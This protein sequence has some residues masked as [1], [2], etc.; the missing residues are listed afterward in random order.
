MTERRRF[1]I[2]VR[3]LAEKTCR[4][5]DLESRQG[6]GPAGAAA[7]H[8]AAA[9]VRA[10]RP[11]GYKAELPLSTV[12]SRGGLELQISGRADGAFWEEDRWVIEE[13]KAT[14]APPL[15]LG[16]RREPLHAA[17][18][19]LYAAMLARDK[20]LS[21]VAVDLTYVRVPGFSMRTSREI[22]L[23]ERLEQRLLDAALSHLEWLSLI[24]EH[25]ERRDVSLRAL[26]L[27]LREFRPGQ[28]ELSRAVFAAARQEMRLLA[29]APTGS[30]KTAAVLMGGLKALGH[31]HIEQVVFLTAKTSGRASPEA[32]L[33][34]WRTAGAQLVSLTVSARELCCASAGTCQASQCSRA[35]GLWDRL[36]MARRALFEAGCAD[37]SA[38]EAVAASACVCP[39]L[40]GLALVP[41]ADVVVCDYGYLFDPRVALSELTSSRRRLVIVDEAHN[42]VER[43]RGMWSA[44]LRPEAILSAVKRLGSG[45][46]QLNRSA[47]RLARAVAAL[48]DSARPRL[49]IDRG[50]ASLKSLV[51]A[52]TSFVEQVHTAFAQGPSAVDIEALLGVHAECRSVLRL[53][54]RPAPADVWLGSEEEL[55]LFCT[56]PAPRLRAVLDEAGASA[57]LLSATLSPLEY[58][59]RCLGGRPQDPRLALASPFPKERFAALVAGRVSARFRHRRASAPKVAD[60]IARAASSRIGCY[61]AFFPSYEYLETVAPILGTVAPHLD[62]A[63]QKRGASP[64]DNAAFLA[65]LG[66]RDTRS[67]VGLAVLG[68]TFAEAIDLPGDR[69]LGVVIVGLGLPP[70]DERREAIREAFDASDGKGDE[71]AY[72]CPALTKVVQAAGRVIRTESDAGFAL[73]IDDRF[74][75]ERIRH[76]LPR[77]L[78]S[79]CV[80]TSQTDL[81]AR[82]RRHW[83]SLLWPHEVAHSR[84]GDMISG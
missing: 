57:V 55:C 77:S 30:G 45:A 62:I 74:A 32:E 73:L 4:S 69:L 54:E 10:K 61:L 43:G 18:A 39:Y 15:F 25:R 38:V 9:A 81:E 71:Y 58:Y 52:A 28:R 31:G 70:P 7:G 17:Q 60:L 48:R 64:Q 36:P 79:A 49:S 19:E 75:T 53:L 84:A 51:R 29:E 24:L 34:R 37:R 47:T 42:L 50:A 44:S 68:G 83:E 41:W 8:L 2:S 78:G 5:G 80:V 12:V 35:R 67:F 33:E 46:R 72:L 22:L 6:L 20:D 16:A 13:I 76:L 59:H 1:S 65:R 14:T 21:E 23:R 63:A 27:P 40:L 3:A 56:D 11:A 66:P 82:L 26:G